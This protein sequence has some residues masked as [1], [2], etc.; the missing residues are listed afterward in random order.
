MQE[1]YLGRAVESGRRKDSIPITDMSKRVTVLCAPAV[2][3]DRNKIV[4]GIVG[5]KDRN[6]G[7]ELHRDYGT[8]IDR[9]ECN[10][11]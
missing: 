9:R 6:A 4:V 7:R 2:E 11:M 10:G 3:R 1:N 8:Y 5:E